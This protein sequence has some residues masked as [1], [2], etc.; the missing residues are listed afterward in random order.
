M[1]DGAATIL[2]NLTVTGPTGSGYTTAFP[3]SASRPT[4]SNNNYVGGQTVPNFA[5]VQS[6]ADGDICIYT[7]ASAHL[8]WDQVGE[9]TAFGVHSPTR[10]LDTRARR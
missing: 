7:S 6:D 2:G 3:C 9:T 8:I 10:L 5:V 4:A 1:S